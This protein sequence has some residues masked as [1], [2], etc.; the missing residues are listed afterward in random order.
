MSGTI[1]RYRAVLFIDID[2]NYQCMYGRNQPNLTTSLLHYLNIL[3]F[4][5][6]I[7]IY[8]YIYLFIGIVV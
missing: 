1:Y 6:Y 3:T 8:I 5:L 7:Y 4:L 2:M